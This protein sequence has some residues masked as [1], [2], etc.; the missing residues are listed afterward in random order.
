MSVTLRI[1]KIISLLNNKGGV[2]KTTLAFNLSKNYLRNNRKVI[3]IDFDQQGNLSRMLPDTTQSDIKAEELKELDADYIIVDT[4]PTFVMDHVNL[5]LESDLIL[6]PFQLERMDIEQM[7]SLLATASKLNVSHKVKIIAIHSGKS[8][9]MYK[10]LSPLVDEICE[11]YG[12]EI[13]C[14]MRRN[15]AVSQANLNYKTVFEISSPPEVRA[16]FKE[17]FKRVGESLSLLRGTSRIASG[18]TEVSHV[19]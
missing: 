19:Q 16:E 18:Q 9:K 3:S 2:S 6:V 15:Q 7:R 14:E 1:P 4:G 17:L 10:A 5:M 12:I 13:L 8:T 11:E